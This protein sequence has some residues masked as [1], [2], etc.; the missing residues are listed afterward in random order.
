MIKSRN[1]LSKLSCKKVRLWVNSHSSKVPGY[2]TC[3]LYNFLLHNKHGSRGARQEKPDRRR[4]TGEAGQKDHNRRAPAS[5]SLAL[6]SPG[7]EKPWPGE[8]LARRSPGQEDLRPGGTPTRRTPGQK[9]LL[10]R[11]AEARRSIGQEEHWQ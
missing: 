1:L 3:Y 6:R 8:A 10:L 4:R 5:R 11:G 9:E 2:G 7:Q